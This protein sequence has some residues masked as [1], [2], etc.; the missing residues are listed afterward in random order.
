MPFAEPLHFNEMKTVTRI[1]QNQAVSHA[2]EQLNAACG[3]KFTLKPPTRL[4]RGLGKTT[5]GAGPII[6]N[7]YVSLPDI[8]TTASDN[9]CDSNKTPGGKSIVSE[10]N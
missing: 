10:L 2:F 5:T 1:A 9:K 8:Y 6:R 3:R 7:C 4:T